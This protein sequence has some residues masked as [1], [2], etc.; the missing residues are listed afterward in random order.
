[1][2]KTEKQTTKSIYKSLAAFQQE[3]PVIHKGTKGYG[4]SYSDLPTIFKVI[5]PLLKKHKLGFTQLINEGCIETILFHVDT[6]Q[7]ITSKTSIPEDVNLKGMNQFQ[8]L[9]SAVTYIRRYALSSMLGIV[10]DKDTDAA[11]EQIP[12]KKKLS[13]DRFQKGLDKI[14]S[15]LITKESFLNMLVGYDLTEVQK[16]AIKL[17]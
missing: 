14:E 3:C 6:G 16:A 4:Y 17:L 5:N 8:V 9:G 1:M 11:G 13:T 12:N 15:G 7:T 2:S 10:T